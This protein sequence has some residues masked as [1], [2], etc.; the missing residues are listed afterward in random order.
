MGGADG[1]AVATNDRGMS[2]RGK[3][4]AILTIVLIITGLASV[5]LAQE[6]AASIPGYVPA[7]S[8]RQVDASFATRL[9]T[10]MVPLL[11]NMNRPIPLDQVEIGLMDDHHIN[12]ANAGG[13]HF[14]VTTGLLEKANDD[15]LRAVMAHEIAHADLGH[16]AKAQRLGIGLTLG[17]VLLEQ[18]IP[19]SQALT[20]IAG[21]LI[22]SS[23][24]RKEEYQADAHG[25][26]ILRRAGYD[27]RS[28]L[29]DT[30]TWLTKVEGSGSGGFFATHPA[31]GD[32]IAA[33]RRLPPRRTTR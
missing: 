23:Y 10:V 28:L 16:V 2:D 19:G 17:M 8:S 5:G 30:L 33:V 18:V 24:G 32:R 4:L 26:E 29:A 25:V 20:P 1:P 13:G 11:Q 31:T 3:R 6:P 9:T 14:Y 12:A 27:G 15:Q 22:Q 7:P 21:Q